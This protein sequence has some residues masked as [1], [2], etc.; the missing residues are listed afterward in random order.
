MEAEQ[1]MTEWKV[2][3]DRNSEGNL[4]LLRIEWKYNIPKP[5]GQN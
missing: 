4:K 3:Q 1:L 2:S 5:I